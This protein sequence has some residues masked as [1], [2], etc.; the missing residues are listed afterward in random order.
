MQRPEQDMLC[1]AWNSIQLRFKLPA[2]VL[3]SPVTVKQGMGARVV[4]GVSHITLGVL[5]A[6]AYL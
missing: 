2:G 6:T 3:M 1:V 4:K 5:D